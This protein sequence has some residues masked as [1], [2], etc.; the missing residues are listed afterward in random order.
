[1]KFRK[2]GNSL[3]MLKST[4]G[5]I[6]L[7]IQG[8]EFYFGDSRR[9]LCSLFPLASTEL[10]SV[11][12]QFSCTRKCLVNSKTVFLHLK[13][14]ALHL[15]KCRPA[16]TLNSFSKYTQQQQCSVIK[17]PCVPLLFLMSL[18]LRYPVVDLEEW[19]RQPYPWS[20]TNRAFRIFRPVSGPDE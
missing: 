13:N 16:C 11:A 2:T 4:D 3:Y 8:E 7:I 6:S 19:V 1:M 10:S 14:V 12:N 15:Q 5:E 20:Q 18:D 9:P 17:Y